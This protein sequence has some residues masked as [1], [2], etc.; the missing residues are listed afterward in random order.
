MDKPTM[1]EVD[2]YN[3]LAESYDAM[4]RFDERLGR[5]RDLLKFWVEAGCWQTVLD[6][7][8][9]TG[10][11]AIALA[12]LGI[13]TTASDASAA[14]LEQAQERAAARCSHRLAAFAAA[15]PRAVGE[16]RRC[17]ALPWQLAAPCAEC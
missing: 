12:S 5:E 11:H 4:T 16:K 13:K 8:C 10:L 6:A 7:A 17:R 1:Q 2:F 14:M 9:G 3:Q 15:G